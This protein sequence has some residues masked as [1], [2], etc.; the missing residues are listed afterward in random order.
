MSLSHRPLDHLVLPVVDLAT[1]RLRLSAL[2]FAVAP[3]ARH[4]FGTENACV[5]F[6]DSTYLEPLAIADQQ[7]YDQNIARAEFVRRDRAYRFRRGDDGLSAI[8]FKSD[9]AAA[10]HADFAEA[11]IGVGELFSFSRPYLRADGAQATAGFRLAF[12]ADLRAP[13]LFFFTCERMQS[14]A[15][16]EALMG[17]QNG[18]TGISAILLGEDNPMEFEPLLQT[19]TGAGEADIHPDGFS[20][21]AL[22]VR[23]SVF[24]YDH[25]YRN[26]GIARSGAGRGLEPAAIVFAAADLENLA[27]ILRTN[28]IASRQAGDSICVPPAPGQG[29]TFI[30]REN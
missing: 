30:F 8:V 9:D 23:L 4:P 10:D 22:A 12:A 14:L 1:A 6:A 18:V 3:E 2:G 24:T 11:G 16:D 19:L 25:L 27:D 7:I 28:D 26:H 20:T 29:V 5:Y 17:H 15:P 21:D 13:D